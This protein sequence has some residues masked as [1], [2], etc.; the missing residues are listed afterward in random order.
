MCL[1]IPR[2]IRHT[3]LKT[4]NLRSVPRNAFSLG[5]SIIFDRLP[6]SPSCQ[7]RELSEGRINK[8]HSGG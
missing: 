5:N 8:E 6:I 7:T 1:K 3:F 2:S 4:A